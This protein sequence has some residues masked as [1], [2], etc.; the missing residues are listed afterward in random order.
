MLEALVKGHT[1]VNFLV[2]LSP[3]G[4]NPMIEHVF[5]T[6]ERPFS[7]YNL[8]VKPLFVTIIEVKLD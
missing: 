5:N 7:T 6:P 1:I 2:F 3:P 4:A 8:Y